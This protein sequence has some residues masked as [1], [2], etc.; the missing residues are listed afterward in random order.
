MKKI[1]LLFT[2]LF[3]FGCSSDKSS[4]VSVS[5]SGKLIKV[6]TSSMGSTDSYIHVI[7][8]TYSGDYIV[9]VEY[10]D[11]SDKTDYTY[12]NG[13][14]ISDKYYYNGNLSETNTYT[15]TG[16]LITSVTYTE[17]STK[18]TFKYS[19]DSNN[20]VAT[21]EGY[22]ATNALQLSEYYE[23]DTQ[24]NVSK[25]TSNGSVTTFEYDTYKN[26]VY[27]IFPVAY[28]KIG[29]EYATTNNLTNSSKGDT[30]ILKYNSDKYPTEIINSENGVPVEKQEFFYQ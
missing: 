11:E 6:I 14:L 26:P 13:K 30:W 21:K 22:S 27:L 12:E 3:I 2:T 28:N 8:L 1:I 20:R 29:G 16:D 17:G 25:K 15:Y 7:N 5:S 10:P 9:K 18:K 19:Y 23:Y 4:D 24:G